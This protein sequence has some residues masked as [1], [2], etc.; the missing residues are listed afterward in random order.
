MAY[1]EYLKKYEKLEDRTSNLRAD[2]VKLTRERNEAEADANKYKIKSK[3]LH[4][5]SKAFEE[6]LS[7]KVKECD[8][9]HKTGEK[10]KKINE[11]MRD[12]IEKLQARL[13]HI[14]NNQ[15]KSLE[16]IIKERDQQL[17]MLKQLL[18]SNEI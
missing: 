8:S 4:Q 6:Q 10:L 2:L 13:K 3:I 7:E 15:L 14:T 17:S 16:E 9:R 11:E 1:T 18:K 12:E 5:K